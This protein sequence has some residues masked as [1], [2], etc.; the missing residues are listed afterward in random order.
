MLLL[1]DDL[2]YVDCIFF[3]FFKFIMENF[4]YAQ[5]EK[6]CHINPLCKSYGLIINLPMVYQPSVYPFLVPGNF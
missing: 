6:E 5:K 1:Q 2:F 4:N 3:Y